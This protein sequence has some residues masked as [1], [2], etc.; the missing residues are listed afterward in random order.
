MATTEFT[1]SMIEDLTC[2]ICYEIFGDVVSLH[3][4]H[5]FCRKC[6]TDYW[7]CSAV[8]ECPMC[9][10]KS[11]MDDL[12]PNYTLSSIVK[13][14]LKQQRSNSTTSC[15]A[16]CRSHGEK[17]KLYCLD[18]K[19]L[20]CDVCQNSHMHVNHKTCSIQEAAKAFKEKLQD[21]MQFKLEK[22]Y[23]VKETY[24]LILEELQ[25]QSQATEKQ[26]KKEFEK[27]HQFLFT[28]EDIF[29]CNLKEEEEKK[30]HAVEEKIQKL[31]KDI[32]DLTDK[33]EQLKEDLEQEDV[34]ILMNSEAIQE[35][36][37]GSLVIPEV[38]NDTLIDKTEHLENLQYR[39]WKNMLDI[40]KPAN[41]KIEL[42]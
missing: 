18:H 8:Q 20:I 11:S 24:D 21:V 42:N 35:R 33:M 15:I 40:I 41:L 9:R 6:V 25:N 34:V 37:F 14:F 36:S 17:F 38:E 12:R 19:K 16:V 4:G 28:E 1:A 32:S 26:I 10:E 23:E 22:F 7:E 29:I 27:L 30:M 5:N 2:S 39:V 13:T 31:C 3:C